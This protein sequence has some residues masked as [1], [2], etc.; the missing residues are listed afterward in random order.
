MFPKVSKVAIF[1]K[2]AKGGNKGDSS[3][4]ADFLVQVRKA[5]NLGNT[6]RLMVWIER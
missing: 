4:M 5:K 1:L 3:K 2:I 6:G